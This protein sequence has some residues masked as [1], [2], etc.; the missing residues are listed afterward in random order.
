MKYTEIRDCFTKQ[1]SLSKVK[2]QNIISLC[3]C[4]Y[5]NLYGLYPPKK[6]VREHN[7][8]L[9]AICL[10]HGESER[11]RRIALNLNA[12]TTFLKGYVR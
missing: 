8:D 9:L 12:K 3:G 10:T 6:C 11:S 7:D 4:V 2:Q 1:P 5:Y